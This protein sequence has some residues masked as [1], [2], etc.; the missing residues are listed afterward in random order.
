MTEIESKKVVVPAPSEKV[1]AFL[2]DMNNI[3]KLLPTGKYTEWKSDE[4]SCSF[5][6][7]GAYTIVLNFVEATPYSQIRYVS[8]DGSPFSF[9]LVTHLNP[10]GEGSGGFMKCEAD[11]N[12]FLKMVVQGPLKNL[13]DYMAD[14]LTQQF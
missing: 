8:G 4:K 3:E 7:Q 2:C 5:K 14:K 11:I 10:E 1:F 12:P 6:I 13:F 9:S